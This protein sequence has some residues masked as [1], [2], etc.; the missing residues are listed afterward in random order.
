MTERGGALVHM[1]IRIY[2]LP[3]YYCLLFCPIVFDT[4]LLKKY[5][6]KVL[7]IHAITYGNNC[8]F[9]GTS[10]FTLKS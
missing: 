10:S 9:F 5:T 2:L 8:C 3:F 6:V 7:N 1:F 4:G